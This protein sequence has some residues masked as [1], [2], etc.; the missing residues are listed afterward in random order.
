MH[1]PYA[2]NASVL[3]FGLTIGFAVGGAYK[4][5][6][7]ESSASKP[8]ASKP[9]ADESSAS[10]SSASKPFARE[11]SASKPSA[12]KLSASKSST[13]ET[14]TVEPFAGEP[15]TIKSS[16]DASKYSK[17]RPS[18][19]NLQQLIVKDLEEHYP[20]PRTYINAEDFG[21]LRIECSDL[22]LSGD[23]PN[24]DIFL[25]PYPKDE[26]RKILEAKKALD[27]DSLLQ[28]PLQ[29]KYL[30][31]LDEANNMSRLIECCI[32]K[33][34]KYKTLWKLRPM[35]LRKGERLVSHRKLLGGAEWEVTK[36]L[37]MENGFTPHVSPILT[38]DLEMQPDKL[39]VGEFACLLFCTRARLR[40]KKKYACHQIIPVT[41]VSL[42]LRSARIVHGYFDTSFDKL[43]VFKSPILKLE[44]KESIENMHVLLSWCVGE[45]IG[46][47][48]WK[49]RSR[50][51]LC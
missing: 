24:Q 20:P 28:P 14:S 5:H 49:S 50:E 8:L 21:S 23:S 48:K 16:T 44:G 36:V 18:V 31:H 9:S 26:L 29:T 27:T 46:E 40:Q 19:W 4:S 7:G 22:D 15:T 33:G 30:D 47:T 39:S 32:S 1:H 6:T 17:T 42:S 35:D 34:L 10:E 51:S 37:D 45:P 38:D 43:R 13:S 12:S 2:L 25:R 11:C 3:L 41:V